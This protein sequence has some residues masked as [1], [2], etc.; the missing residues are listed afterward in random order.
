MV[1]K[2]KQGRKPKYP[3]KAFEEISR[4][5]EQIANDSSTQTDI[6]HSFNY[7]DE[8]RQR[9]FFKKVFYHIFDY[10]PAYRKCIPTI[11]EE[12]DHC[13]LLVQDL[14]VTGIDGRYVD[15]TIRGRPLTIEEALSRMG[16]TI[17]YN[18]HYFY[19]IDDPGHLSYITEDDLAG[20]EDSLEPV[21]N[22]TQYLKFIKP[23]YAQS[24][25]KDLCDK[26][27]AWIELGY[28]CIPVDRETTLPNPV[29]SPYWTYLEDEDIYQI[30]CECGNVF[31]ANLHETTVQLGFGNEFRE[32]WAECPACGKSI[33][34]KI[35]RRR[36]R[37]C[38][39]IFDM[40]VKEAGRYR[41]F[42]DDECKQK[43][44]RFERRFENYFS[45]P[46][47][48]KIEMDN[49]G[50]LYQSG[51]FPIEIERRF[52]VSRCRYCGKE[53][54]PDKRVGSDFCNESCK[55]AFKYKFKKWRV[56]HPETTVEE[57]THILQMGRTQLHTISLRFVR[58]KWWIVGGAPLDNAY[59]D[60][61]R[62]ML[63]PEFN[64][65]VEWI[66]HEN[67]KEQMDPQVREENIERLT[68]L[69]KNGNLDI[70]P[71]NEAFYLKGYFGSEFEELVET[72]SQDIAAE[73]KE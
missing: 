20:L 16:K 21:R 38:G 12:N 4:K 39:K 10:D 23:T 22:E 46:G 52:I 29:S 33:G 7:E 65:V 8:G 19:V 40:P 3:H 60:S 53:L 14:E 51:Y 36:C 62:E 50:L 28:T 43:F 1:E 61:W 35:Y 58:L 71:A 6:Q 5:Y 70:H 63:G 55:K 13:E 45:R 25:H 54:S 17:F 44:L 34:E 42:C 9:D 41:E 31:K 37:Y 32:V 24:L 11:I 59:V 15:G 48:S 64:R 67:E 49:I 68:N 72:I 47:S 2:V 56:Q 73:K 26:V 66:R 57:F 18:S 27:K 30:T 69:L